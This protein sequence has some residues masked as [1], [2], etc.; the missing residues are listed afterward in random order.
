MA[1]APEISAFGDGSHEEGETGLTV[2]G[3][4]FGAFPGSVWMFENADG[5]GAADELT[6]AGAW[7]DIQIAGVEIPAAPNNAPGTV[8]LRVLHENLAWS[9][10]FQFS[11]SASGG[12]VTVGQA[13]ETDSALAAV[14]NRSVA[15]GIAS[16]TDTALAISAWTKSKA[17]G[18]ALELDT[19]LRLVTVSTGE[20]GM[21]GEGVAT[22]TTDITG[23]PITGSGVVRAAA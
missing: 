18:I 8:Y 1:L 9:Q 10:G 15:V 6:V 22:W 4:G 3:G 14:A 23:A 16:E 17:V 5:S 2:D 11:L 7:N 13:Q 19:A 20:F 12:P 21:S